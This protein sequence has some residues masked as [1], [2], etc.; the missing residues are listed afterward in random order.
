[1]GIFTRWLSELG[2]RLRM[3]LRRE[4]FNRDLQ[5]EMGLHIEL[6]QQEDLDRRLSPEDA[7]SAARRKFG[8][9]TLLREF[10]GDA[11]GWSWLDQFAQDLRYGAR[12]MVRAPAFTAVAVIALSLGIG[13]STAIF[14]VVNAVL[15]RPLAYK[16]PARLVTILHGGSDP[17][18]A[19]NYTD[20][21]DQ[22]RSFAAMGAAQYWSP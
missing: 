16:D 6:R 21:R 18:A 19:A 2:R 4:Q 11:W 17:V 9:T 3:L 14:T 13:A 7:H 5:D 22:S 10:S 15:L 8:N 1:M 12:A 20:W